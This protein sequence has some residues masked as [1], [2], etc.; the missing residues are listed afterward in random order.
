VTAE[1]RQRVV[2]AVGLAIVVASSTL[3]ASLSWPWRGVASASWLALVIAVGGSFA[4]WI[5]R[6]LLR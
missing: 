4:A 3:L 5:A 2:R 1:S 6:D